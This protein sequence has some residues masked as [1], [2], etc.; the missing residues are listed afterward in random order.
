MST[1]KINASKIMIHS[2]Q[3]PNLHSLF[4][5]VP[6]YLFYISLLIT[7]PSTSFAIPWDNLSTTEK[8]VL[9]PYHKQW[10]TISESQQKHLRIISRKWQKMSRKERHYFKKKIRRWKQMTPLQRQAVKKWFIWFN[11][12]SPAVKRSIRARCHWFKT[13]PSVRKKHLHELYSQVAI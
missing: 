10:Q 4:L 11:G 12:Q 6:I 9:S 1:Y 8:T 7:L 5:K 3:Y 13:L 2:N